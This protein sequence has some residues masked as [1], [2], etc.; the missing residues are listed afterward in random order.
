MSEMSTAEARTI[1]E[2]ERQE[3][4]QRC[5][6]AL[7]TLL[8]EHRCRLACQLGIVDGRIVGNVVLVEN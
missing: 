8:Q 4:L 7:N 3:R 6:A 1:L 5:Q 2:R